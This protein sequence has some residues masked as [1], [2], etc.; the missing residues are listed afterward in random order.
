MG[1]LIYYTAVSVDGFVADATGSLA[2]LDGL[3][4]DP[5]GL[6]GWE[7]F[8]TGVGALVMGR[9][10]YDWLVSGPLADPDTRWPHRQPGW[11]MTHRAVARVPAGADLTFADA[12][13]EQVVSQMRAAAG[14][15][16]LWLAGG[17]VTAG[18]FARAGL[19]DEIWLSVAPVVLGGGAPVLASPVTLRL[20][21]AGRN[22]DFAAL[23]YLVDPA[24]TVRAS[25]G[26]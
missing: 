12:S 8:D 1:R 25:S 16:D 22:G 3:D 2:W 7:T 21:Y 17:G 20:A 23:R 11:V 10:T 26:T 4:N 14:A 5:E 9:T 6:L 13:P 19:I 18:S 24:G 15:A